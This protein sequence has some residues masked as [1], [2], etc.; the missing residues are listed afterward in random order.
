MLLED[1]DQ[2][3]VSPDGS[4]MAFFSGSEFASDLWLADSDGHNPH[5]L[6]A[7]GPEQ[8]GKSRLCCQQHGR[9]MG[10]TSPICSERAF[11]RTLLLATR[12]FCT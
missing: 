11:P 10:G 3:T 4:R 5:R 12:I 6:V 8:S 9:P 1:A 7:H 2:G